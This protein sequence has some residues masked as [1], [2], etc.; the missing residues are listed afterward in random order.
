MAVEHVFG[1]E[2]P[3]GYHLAGWICPL[4]A[5]LRCL[6]CTLTGGDRTPLTCGEGIRVWERRLPEPEPAA[7][8]PWE[9]G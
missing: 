1:G 2:Q 7:V 9:R 5:L 8:R 3:E 6:G 4:E